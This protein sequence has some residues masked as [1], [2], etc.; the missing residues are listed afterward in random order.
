MQRLDCTF[1][2]SLSAVWRQYLKAY[3]TC[4]GCTHKTSISLWN[5]ASNISDTLPVVCNRFTAR[6]LVSSFDSSPLE[7]YFHMCTFV[8]SCCGWKGEK[9]KEKK[10]RTEQSCSTQIDLCNNISEHCEPAQAVC[11]VIILWWACP[12]LGESHFQSEFFYVFS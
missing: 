12:C 3:V 7:K 9:K 4:K 5:H 6:P 11:Y 8:S 10:S 1:H 2:R